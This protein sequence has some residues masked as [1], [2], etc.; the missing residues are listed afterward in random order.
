M[1]TY[2]FIYYLIFKNVENSFDQMS[3]TKNSVSILL[4]R[5]SNTQHNY[6]MYYKW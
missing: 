2:S 4:K 3:V 6:K 5:V 1:N